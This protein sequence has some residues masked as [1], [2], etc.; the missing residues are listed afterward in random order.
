MNYKAVFKEKLSNLLF[1]EVNFEGFK[2]S[3]GIPSNVKLKTDD[4]YLPISSK[5]ITSNAQN[6]LKINNL[7]IYY[8]IEGM[9]MALGADKN[10]KYTEDYIILIN[11]IKDSE[12]C[13]RSL[14]ADRIKKDNLIEAYLIL[15]GLVISTGNEEY[16]K[17]LL[18]VGESIR[19]KDSAFKDNLLSD[20]DE[21]EEEFENLPER[22]LYKAIIYKD[23]NDYAKARVY[24]NEFINKGGKVTKEIKVIMNDI[25][26]I[27]NY[28]KAV[29]L[30]DTKPEKAIGIFLSLLE[31]FDKNPLIYYYLGVGFRKIGRYEEAIGYL[32]E[33]IKLE[34]GLLEAVTELGLNYACLKD[35]ET[36][37]K[38][39]RKAF[40]ASK[41]VEI[42]TNL[43]MCYLNIGDNENAKLHY[44][45][46]KDIDSEDEIVKKLESTIRNLK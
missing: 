20:I 27:A 7:P 26:N 28:E 44:K 40:E 33:C 42:C 24:M 15:K 46:A 30:L 14:V 19:E 39:F 31:N 3:I 38:Y 29:Q 5:Y 41:D 17:K 25:E 6:T 37:I 1:L 4:L 18:L 34:S 2:K 10:L 32:H 22:D 12:V 13:G 11:N 23:D 16:Y 21:G 36:A 35:F 8:F 45:I 9:F 43:V